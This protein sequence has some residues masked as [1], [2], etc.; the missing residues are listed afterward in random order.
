MRGHGRRRSREEEAIRR[1][2]EA[3]V[4]FHLESRVEDLIAAG[5]SEKDA[6]EKAELEFGDLATVRAELEAIDVRV[7]DRERRRDRWSVLSAETRRAGRAMVREP[8]FFLVAV[9]TLTLGLAGAAAIFTLLDGIVL[10]PLPYADPGRLVRLSS[11]VPGVGADVEWGLAKGEFLYFREQVRELES[12][13]LYR[14]G[15]VTVESGRGAER[16]RVAEVEPGVATVLR[17]RPLQ[18]RLI[19]GSDNLEP[20]PRVA[21]VSARWF[22]RH[23]A[24]NARV[25]GTTLKID[26]NPVEVIG[27]LPAGAVLPDELE[28]GGSAVDVWLPLRLDPAEPAR[29]THL[30][31]SIA[32]V[33]A[34]SD[35]T[36][37]AVELSRLTDRLPDALPTAYSPAFM[38]RS[39]FRTAVT[40]LREDVVGEVSRVLWMLLA[41]VGI[42][43]AIAAANVANLFLVRAEGRRREMALRTALGARGAH[44]LSSF[45]AETV[46][47]SMLAAGLAALLAAAAV[48]LVVIAAPQG[49]PRLETVS[50]GWR[51]AGLLLLLGLAAGIALG[52]VPFLRRRLDVAT[53]RGEGR[54]H[55]TNRHAVS[56]RSFLII[57]QFALALVLLSCSGL[58]LRSFLHLRAANPGIAAAGVFAVSLHIPATPRHATF[59]NAGVFQRELSER[60]EALTAVERV[61]LTDYLPLSGP[62]GCTVIFSEEAPVLAGEMPPCVT[63]ASVDPGFFQTLGIAVRGEASE[64]AEMQSGTGGAVVSEALARRLWPGQDAIGRTIRANNPRNPYY[65]VIGVAADVRGDGVDRPPVEVVY[66]P[67]MPMEDALISAT[68]PQTLTLV[69]R[70]TDGVSDLAQSIRELIT[71]FAPEVALGDMRSMESI[72]AA[73]MA[74]VSFAAALLLLAA[75]VAL[76]LSA[77]GIYGVMG[78]LVRQRHTEIGVRMALGANSAHVRRM[79]VLQSIALAGPG[80]VIGL[81]AASMAT[82][83]LRSLLFEVQPGDP[84]ALGVAALALVAVAIIA[85]V[86]PAHRAA[87]VDPAHAL[88]SNF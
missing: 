81:F 20:A 12:L 27:V 85:C 25:L 87:R 59:A 23:A 54:G 61:T 6:R 52:V 28:A 46:L 36:R 34:G 83:V 26:G 69:V 35:L 86:A 37:A 1:R 39:G 13:G 17:L 53:L 2:V 21:V 76:A 56:I 73:S 70:S 15:S 42:V 47:L 68:P 7:N 74:R 51:T 50:I 63:V 24:G 67:L 3:E 60:V 40:P 65:R 33:A 29:N 38:E 49:L 9:V 75:T 44:L 43:L 30:F 5:D 32:R 79:I 31:R 4:A 19:E 18:G 55:T 58:L 66:F 45:C 8:A 64:W 62:V 77:V 80:I 88:H 11:P 84:F 16:L 48:R 57:T 72:V 41:A 71:D 82:N 14:L 22:E 10:R 78:F